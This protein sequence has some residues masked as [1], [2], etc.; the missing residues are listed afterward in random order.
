MAKFCT[1]EFDR[2]KPLWH[3]FIKEDYD[4]D[5]S[6]VFILVSHLLSDGMGIMTLFTMVNQKLSSDFVG[7]H[8]QIPFFLY[9]ILPLFYLPKRI[10]QFF[11]P[12]SKIK[13]DPKM[14]PLQLNTGKQS[15]NKIYLESKRYKLDDL[16]KCYNKF[17]KM[18]LNDY[19]LASISA[20]M[21]SYLDKLGVEDQTHFTATIP[22][23]MKPL[24]NSL[25]EVQFDNRLS[26]ATI[27]IPLSTDLEYVMK[28]TRKSLEV[29]YFLPNL[30]TGMYLTNFFGLCPVALTRMVM[31]I[32]LLM[33][34]VV[35]S[36]TPGPSDSSYFCDRRIKELSGIGPNNGQAG[37]TILISSYLGLVRVQILADKNLKM[38]PKV[39]MEHIEDQLDKSMLKF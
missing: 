33:I 26:A 35:I 2:S 8:R 4:E 5:T 39:L 29:G 21:S 3:L 27:N 10:V 32:K 31:H 16:R 22:V 37:L 19:M 38:D 18:K 1:H 9:Y 13:A 14:Y 11:K 36:N 34:N 12:G 25:E 24:P 20:G 6:V 28:E 17:G 7:T 30:R 15:R 23:N